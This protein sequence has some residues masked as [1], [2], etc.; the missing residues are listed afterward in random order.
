[1]EKSA[2]DIELEFSGKCLKCKGTGQVAGDTLHFIQIMYT[3]LDCGGMGHP[4]EKW[5]MYLTQ[6]AT[7]LCERLKNETVFKQRR[8]RH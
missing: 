5:R 1:M 2:E 4:P 3:C 7:E 6:L 8:R